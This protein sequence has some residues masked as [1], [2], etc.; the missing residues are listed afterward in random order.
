MSNRNKAIEIAV[1]QFE[2]CLKLA[3]F[4]DGILKPN[5]T[6]PLFFRGIVPKK[7]AKN[8]YLLIY[9]V[10]D[11]LTNTAADNEVLVHN[12]YI[13]YSV[14]TRTHLA[15]AKFNEYVENI[16]DELHKLEFKLDYGVESSNIEEDT[17]I[18]I[19]SKPV[20]ADKF[21]LLEGS[22]T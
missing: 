21:I 15:D 5:S 22:A 11:N 7:S 17:E 6:K 2:G 14:Q 20:T 8:K 3:G 9:T 4:E 18:V 16:E 12:V 19:H 1:N 10:T 13:D